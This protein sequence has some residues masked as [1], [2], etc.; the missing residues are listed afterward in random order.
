MIFSY[1]GILKAIQD[2]LSLLSNWRTTLYHSIYQRLNEAQAYAI[3]KLVYLAEFLYRE[4]NFSTALK[5]RSLLL[6]SKFLSYTPYRKRAPNGN[7]I[8]TADSTG[9]FNNY[10]YSGDPVTTDR[11]SVM[12]NTNGDTLVFC[13]EDTVY[14]TGAK[15]VSE[16]FSAGAV[17]DEG[18]GLVGFLMADTSN[19]FAGNIIKVSGTSN[20]NGYHTV[21]SIIT[22]T[23]VLVTATYNAET[24]DGTEVVVS[25]FSFIPVK[26]GTPKTFTYVAV[27]DES[28][29]VTIYS[30][31]IENE[32][33]EVFIVDADDA[34]LSTVS[35]IGVDT[36]E[37]DHFFLSDTDNYY[38]KIENDYDFEAVNFTFGDD[39]YTKKLV[40]GTRILIK[41][42]ITD[43]DEGNISS[44]DII[45]TFAVDPVDSNNNAVV[46]YITNDEEIGDGSD[47]ETVT[48]IRSNAPNLFNAGYRCGSYNDWI[49]I[50]ENDSRIYKATIW[51]TED[52]ADDTIS[53]NQNKIFVAAISS[54]STELTETQKA[55]ITTDYLKSRKS[56]TEIVSWQDLNIVFALV[57]VTAVISDIDKPTVRTA[58]YNALDSEYGI[59]NTDF[60]VGIK[61][62]N[63]ERVV[64]EVEYIQYHTSEL[65]NCERLNSSVK[66][67]Y[68]IIVQSDAAD[69]DIHL[70]EDTLE[71]W[72]QDYDSTTSEW[73]SSITRVGYDE[74][75]S[76][77]A[78]PNYEITADN[79]TYATSQVSFNISSGLSTA[80]TI[81]EDYRLYMS[82]KTKDSNDELQQ[83]IR[84]PAEKKYITD[85]DNALILTANISG[86]STLTYESTLT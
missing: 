83:E 36:T 72:R 52:V 5:R 77:I 81:N 75:G 64:D 53:T 45:N 23:R 67:N 43:G 69:K 68:A 55:D 26:Q 14:A 7:L 73:E 56:P 42:A 20:Y 4:S 85:I 8:V 17:I 10:T 62:S 40:A 49:T 38:V 82:Y 33:F 19:L 32:E 9:F 34:V 86:V 66:L 25:G 29:V 31:S 80:G 16:T 50:L 59:L 18:G 71:L 1:D 63:W 44:S 79:I 12:T 35:I 2:R 48:S 15:T 39:I 47:I 11:W 54:D 51:T 78:E 41:Y 84:F 21:D 37:T 60:Q 24:F 76:W 57:K 22:N 61:K 28:E 3:D 74:S 46:L 27:G 30:D 6:K 58:V 70:T 65:Y 13:T